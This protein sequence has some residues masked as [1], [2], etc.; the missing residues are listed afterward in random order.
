MTYTIPML[1]SIYLDALRE[2]RLEA[3]KNQVFKEAHLHK[4]YDDA[5]FD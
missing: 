4:P 1:K 5:V 3:C 2:E